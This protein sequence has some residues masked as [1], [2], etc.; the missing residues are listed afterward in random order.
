[1]TLLTM[2]HGSAKYLF[3]VGAALVAGLAIVTFARFGGSPAQ[4]AA[5][6]LAPQSAVV[7]LG[8]RAAEPPISSAADATVA[9]RRIVS[10]RSADAGSARMSDARR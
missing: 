1:M 10:P 7:L 2:H 8:E 5:L 4:D 6:P 3:I 9:A